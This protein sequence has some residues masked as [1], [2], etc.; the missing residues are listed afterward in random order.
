MAVRILFCFFPLYVSYNHACAL[1]SA[2]CKQHGFD[3][4]LYILD[5]LEKFK[6]YLEENQPPTVA[7]SC[8]IEEDYLRSLPF[9][10]AARMAGREVLL[11]G[12]YPRRVKNLSA[13][14]HRVCHGEGEL[15]PFYLDNP[16]HDLVFGEGQRLADLN[17]LPLP[18][19]ELFKPYPFDRDFPFARGKTVLPYHSSRGC[20]FS[21]NFCEVRTQPQAVRI[22]IKVKEDLT[23]ITNK[24]L[25][26]IIYIADESIPVYN[27]KWRESW[28]DFEFPFIAYIRADYPQKLIG[29]LVERGMIG[30]MFGVEAGNEQYRNEVLGKDLTDVHIWTTIETLV[31]HGV[32]YAA[33]FMNGTPGE[34]FGLRNETHQLAEKIKGCGGYVLTY[35]YTDLF[36]EI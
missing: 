5:N 16:E 3:T 7:F 11:G 1:L 27:A 20:P 14:A 26:D 19:Y 21:C 24:Y 34:D 15:L 10:Q 33:F 36:R 17:K 23:F 9:M 6:T 31:K 32:D 35:Q 30:A 22:R 25:P 8:V 2:L 4:S 13:P 18:D 29:W 12:V 28:G